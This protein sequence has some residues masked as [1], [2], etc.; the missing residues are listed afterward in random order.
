MRHRVQACRPRR[1]EQQLE[2]R[3]RHADLRPAEPEADQPVRALVQRDAQG[4]LPGGQP[5]LAGDVEA[6]PQ[7]DAEVPLGGDPRVLDRLAHG[8][9]RDATAHVRVRR[10][11]DL[12]IPDLLARELARHLVGQRPDVLSVPD[13]VHHREKDLDEVGEVAEHEE[14]GQQPGVCR[15]GCGSGVARCQLGDDPR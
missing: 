1:V 10:D 7:H 6:P 11:G 12:G 13:E 8:C 14:I 9:G 15:H 3:A 4:L 5:V 2:R